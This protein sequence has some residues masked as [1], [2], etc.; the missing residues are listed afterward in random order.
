MQYTYSQP[1]KKETQAQLGAE[2]WQ[3]QR[4]EDQFLPPVGS[5]PEGASHKI[6]CE[7]QTNGA[8]KNLGLAC[9]QVGKQNDVLKQGKRSKKHRVQKDRFKQLG[10]R[11]VT[12][13]LIAG[14]HIYTPT[15][16]V[17]AIPNLKEE[18]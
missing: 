17:K 13:S 5:R 4:E 3:Y 15:E 14:K 1:L 18:P 9:I 8:E 11:L 10:L 2:S 12:N 7:N 16:A 6:S